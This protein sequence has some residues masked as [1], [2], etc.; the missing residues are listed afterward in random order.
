MNFQVLIKHLMGFGAACSLLLMFAAC[1]AS[2][3]SSYGNEEW[4]KT[5]GGEQGEWLESAVQTSDNGFALGGITASYGAGGEDVWLVKTDSMGNE[6]WN[7]TFG[8]E[9]NDRAYSVIQTSDGGYALAGHTSSYG[10]GGEDVWLVKTDSVGNEEWNRTFGGTGR[11]WAK[12]VIQI[13]DNG[14]V[15]AG[16]TE[17]Y[18]AGDGDIWLVKTDNAGN[19]KWSKT[20]GGE[21]RDGARSVIQT[22]DGGYAIAG[23][24]QSYGAGGY[25]F[26]LVKTD[27]LGNEEWNRTGGGENNDFACSVIQTP[28][29]GYALT[30]YAMFHSDSGHDYNLW[31]V[32]T[33]PSGNEEWS[34]TFGGIYHDFAYSVIRTSDNG[35]VLAGLISSFGAEDFCL[36]KTDNSGNEEWSKI[37]GGTNWDGAN[38]GVIQTSDGSYILAGITTSY[39][40][41]AQDFW[42]VKTGPGPEG[43]KVLPGDGE[44]TNA[45]AGEITVI[46]VIVVISTLIIYKTYKGGERNAEGQIRRDV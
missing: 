17:S 9:D 34:K 35:Y 18:G 23:Y 3:S 37:F 41:G 33:N 6:E 11:D 25:D 36:V 44:T 13:P 14:Y 4:S 12:S 27:S 42:L 20:F 31:L 24:T 19:E 2:A 40:A 15:L 39:G 8:G 16:I 32:K 26:W 28:D 7:K 1:T 45:P 10:A 30:G 43:G 21:N 5:F 22:S 38:A 46:A 29:N